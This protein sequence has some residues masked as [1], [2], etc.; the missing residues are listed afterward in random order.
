VKRKSWEIEILL[1]TRL[2]D[3]FEIKEKTDTG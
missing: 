2:E 3:S 1:R